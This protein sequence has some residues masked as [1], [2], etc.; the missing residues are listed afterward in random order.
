MHMCETTDQQHGY[1]ITN[2]MTGKRVVVGP[3]TTKEAAF[4][5]MQEACGKQ[6]SLVEKTIFDFT[7]SWNGWEE[8]EYKGENIKFK[9]DYPV[10]C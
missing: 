8:D 2:E 6:K 9:L 4:N 3:F 7:P 10:Y 1:T 5:R